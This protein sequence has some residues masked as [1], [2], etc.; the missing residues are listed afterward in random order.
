M[1]YLH[2]DEK[3]VTAIFNFRVE[4]E[5]KAAVMQRAKDL[6]VNATDLLKLYIRRGLEQGQERAPK[7]GKKA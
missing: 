1:Q 6:N 3:K 5:L 2:D 4:P 7:T